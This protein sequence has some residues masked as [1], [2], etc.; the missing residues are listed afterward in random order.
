MTLHRDSEV[1][2]SPTYSNKKSGILGSKVG[3]SI[4][5]TFGSILVLSIVY[6]EII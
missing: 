3:L 5:Q 4:Q 6:L 1:E 2:Q